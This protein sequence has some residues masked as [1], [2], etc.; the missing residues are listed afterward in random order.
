MTRARSS[1]P[2]W[3]MTSSRVRSRWSTASVPEPYF[4]AAACTRYNVGLPIRGGGSFRSS[5]VVGG[6]SHRAGSRLPLRRKPGRVCDV[7]DEIL[8]RP[9]RTVRQEREPGV[10]EAP[11]H[12]QDA[13][14]LGVQSEHDII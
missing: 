4:D 10:V 9:G 11:R 2:S 13:E 3:W 14:Q 1:C 7:D 8:Y 12:P 5:V 6:A